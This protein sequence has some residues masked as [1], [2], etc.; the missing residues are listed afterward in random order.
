MSYSMS[1][2]IFEGDV[3]DE[4]YSV[5]IVI[6]EDDVWDEDGESANLQL[7]CLQNKHNFSSMVQD[8]FNDFNLIQKNYVT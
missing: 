8:M 2:V 3:W 7:V 1:I 6:F 4:S 5:S